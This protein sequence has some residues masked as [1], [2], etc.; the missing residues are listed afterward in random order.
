MAQPL[1]NGDHAGGG[2]ATTE[3]PRLPNSNAAYTVREQPLGTTRHVRIVGVGAGASGLNLLRTLRLNLDNYEAVL[4]EKNADVGGTWLENR[5]PGCR[6][7][8]P[9]HSY[10]FS[11]RQK[12][13]WTNFFSGAEEIGEYLREVC[14]G[15][16]MRESVKTL[17]QVV[18]ARW[19]EKDGQWELVVK[20]LETGE[21]FSDYATFLVDG[22][23][24]LNNWKWPDVEGLDDFQGTLIHTAR[25]PKDFDHTGKTIAVI[26]NGSSGIQVLPEL[27]RGA[28]KLYNIFRTPTWVLPPRIQAWK[29]MGQA[30]RI[31]SEIEMD[32]K[33]NFSAET[34]EKFQLDP[35][36]YREFVRKVEV[37]VNNA[38]PVVL[39][40]SP[41]QAFARAK[42]TE[43]MT[44]MLG[45][46]P[47][48]CKILIPDF[49]LGCRR[50]TPGHGY[51]QA[52]TQPNV[53][54]R[55]SEIKR[56]VPEGI[57]LE[58]GE[59]LKVDAIV[60]ATGFNTS[61]S[62]RFPIIGRDGNLQDRWKK[63]TP[64]AY[65]SCAV[66]G[67]PNYFMFFGPNAPIG[68]GSVFT[69]S[70]HIA[71]YMTSVIKKCQAEGVKAAAPSR[72]AVADYA[73][74]IA[75][76]MPRTA[77]AAAGGRSWFKDGRA[78]GP[79]TALHPGSRIHFFHMLERFRGEDWEWEYAGAGGAGAGN[80]FAYLGNGFSTRELDPEGDSTWYLNEGAVV[81]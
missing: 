2:G 35:E 53:E 68:H 46:N 8:V 78:D 70:E 49:P 15:E 73:E 58:S 48:L 81:R 65:M 45:G 75:A 32:A 71:K 43:Y 30:G 33:E 61:F 23:G 25:W 37:E 7:D 59:V 38:F 28:E 62:P 26:G 27:Q 29:V 44:L 69:L 42:V 13:D 12:R 55:R 34:I 47:E 60:C 77:W 67:V 66:D 10:Q 21:E 14:D 24:I 9:S 74:H 52:L 50:M 57:E 79:V 40:Q 56:F 80:R 5:Y 6:C 36:F 19:S 17:H 41:V 76:F 22:T 18:E 1:T 39:T 31:L 51:L 16:G 11:W 64:K 54:V 3:S 4:Y 63:E 20:N 72:G